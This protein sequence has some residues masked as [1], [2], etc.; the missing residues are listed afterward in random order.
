M[1]VF[2]VVCACVSKMVKKI[3]FSTF[4]F[5]ICIH[6]NFIYMHI[7]MLT[8]VSFIIVNTVTYKFTNISFLVGKIIKILSPIVTMPAFL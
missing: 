2:V 4:K 8:H 1:C 5:F 6:I 7:Y 3:L